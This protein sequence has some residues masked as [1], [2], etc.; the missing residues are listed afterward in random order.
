L[1][2]FVL[3][4]GIGATDVAMNAHAVEVE[5]AYKR[6]IFSAFHAMW[7]LG[8]LLGATLGGLA[9]AN[10]FE[11][12]TTLT[13]AAIGTLIVAITMR[14][15][16]LPD[17]PNQQRVSEATREEKIAEKQKLKAGNT[18]NRKVL[19]YVLFLGAMAGSAAIAEGTGIDWSAL[20]HARILETTDAYA[21]LALAVFAGAMGVTRLVIDKLVAIRG[22]IFVIRY[23]SLVS[24]IGTGL[25]VVSTSSPVALLGW[26]IA[27]IGI[28]GVVP[29]LFAYSAEVGEKSH[30]GRNMAK[31]VGITYAGVLAGP[32][33]IGFLTIIVPLNIALGLGVALGLFTALGTLLIERRNLNAKAL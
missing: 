33:I 1:A 8:G 30:T 5:K 29:Q 10:N 16:M 17:N 23:G 14:G 9:L 11:M 18:E 13:L 26:L 19:G 31:V 32:A 20:H 2:L 4:L 7:S 21:S 3:G 27:G 24:A 6:P 15:W 28:A 22:R 25:V 12:Q